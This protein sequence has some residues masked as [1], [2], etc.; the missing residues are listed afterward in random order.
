MFH[1]RAEVL[2]IEQ[3]QRSAILKDAL[4]A[5]IEREDSRHHARAGWIQPQSD[6]ASGHCEGMR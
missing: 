6:G 3:Q 4:N 2:T 1:S 5:L